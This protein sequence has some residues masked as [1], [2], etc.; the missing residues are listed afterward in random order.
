MQRVCL[1]LLLLLVTACARLTGISMADSERY[2]IS[3]SASP[4]QGGLPAA[5]R[6]AYDQAGAKCTAAGKTM[7]LADERQFPPLFGDGPSRVDLV[8]FCR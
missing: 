2:T 3:T 5:T 8:F 6:A 7:A 4:T 1:V